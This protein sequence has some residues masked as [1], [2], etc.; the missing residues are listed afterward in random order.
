MSARVACIGNPIRRR[1]APPQEQVKGAP[2][3]IVFKVL[4]PKPGGIALG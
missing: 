1:G 3:S 4:P 2:D